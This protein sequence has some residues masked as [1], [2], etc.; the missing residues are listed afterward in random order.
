MVEAG[1]IQAGSRA[2]GMRARPEASPL[3]D[4]TDERFTRGFT[5]GRYRP[6]FFT[7]LKPEPD[8]TLQNHPTRSVDLLD[9]PHTSGQC[10]LIS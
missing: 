3:L 2:D 1:S 10:C 9:H 5:L 6:Q 7:T 8:A 4:S